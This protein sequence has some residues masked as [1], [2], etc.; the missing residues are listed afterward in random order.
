MH[1]WATDIGQR[2]QRRPP[3]YRRKQAAVTFGRANSIPRHDGALLRSRLRARLPNRRSLGPGAL[4]ERSSRAISNVLPS[5]R[6]RPMLRS[7][8]SLC[9]WM[10]FNGVDGSL[11][12]SAACSRVFSARAGSPKGLYIWGSVGPRQDD[13]DGSLFRRDALRAETARPLPRIHGGRP[14]AH[15]DGPDERTGRP[16]PA[17][18][19]GHRQRGTAPLLRRIACHR[20]R[21]CND[22]RAAVRSV[23]SPPA[24]L[25]SQRR[26]SRHRGSTK[27][28]SIASCSYP[29][30]I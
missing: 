6:L 11:A 12:R 9:V 3:E 20:H 28:A 15:R 7:R 18:R 8:R 30:S 17:R 14:R 19:A 13:A 23:C 25:S 10:R 24:R 4:W 29:L 1:F 27:T 16:D 22:P 21:R 5:A 26:T 2:L